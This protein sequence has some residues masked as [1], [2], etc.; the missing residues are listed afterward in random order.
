MTEQ[1]EQINR[2]IEVLA[3]RIVDEAIVA[4]QSLSHEAH[5]TVDCP[6]DQKKLHP[7]LV[8][9][10]IMLTTP[11]GGGLGYD[12]SHETEHWFTYSPHS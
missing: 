12:T 7:N 5:I 4:T 8:R 11:R 2:T 10:V 3:A 1:L 9:L 6:Y